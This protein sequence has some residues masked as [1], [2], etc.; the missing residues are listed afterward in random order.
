MAKNSSVRTMQSYTEAAEQFR[1]FLAA[2]GLPTTVANLRREHIEAFLESLLH[3]G[4]SAGTA[5]NRYRS[6][7]QLFRWLEEDGEIVHS[8]MGRMRPPDV[9]EKAVPVLTDEQMR[10]ILSG[11]AQMTFDDVRDA[12]ILMLLYDTGGR[13]AEVTNLAWVDSDPQ[14]C[15]VDLDHATI[16]VRG[17]RGRLRLVPVGRKT[18]EAI[19]RYIRKRRNHPHAD[20]PWLWLGKKGR[21]RES[22]VSQMLDRRASA[23]GVGHVHPHQFRHTFAQTFLANG[24]AE[25]DLMRLAGWQSADMIRRYGTAFA[26]D[27]ARAAHRRFSPGD[28]L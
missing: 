15:D 11:C 6:L 13:L 10:S 21:L 17:Q 3:S 7:Q 14:S 4:R 25:G 5:A 22:G 1:A 12:A 28:R 23:V 24:G 18:V 8:P 16:A 9:P 19:D 26:D 2:Q 27:R 20:E